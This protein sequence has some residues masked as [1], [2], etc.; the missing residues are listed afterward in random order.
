MRVV[1]LERG[2]DKVRKLRTVHMVSVGAA[3]NCILKK[4]TLENQM[5]TKRIVVQ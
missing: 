1:G 3:E 5:P 2:A 4:P